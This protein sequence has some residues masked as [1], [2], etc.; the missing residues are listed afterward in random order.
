MPRRRSDRGLRRHTTGGSRGRCRLGRVRSTRPARRFAQPTAKGALS[1]RSRGR[2]DRQNR[3]ARLLQACDEP[4]AWHDCRAGNRAMQL[5]LEQCERRLERGRVAGNDPRHAASCLLVAASTLDAGSD[6]RPRNAGENSSWT[7]TDRAHSTAYVI[8]QRGGNFGCRGLDVRRRR[9]A[10][11]QGA[12]RRCLPRPRP[13]RRPSRPPIDMTPTPTAPRQAPP[14]GQGRS[15]GDRAP[16]R[17]LL[18][19]GAQDRRDRLLV[20]ER[21][22]PD[23]FLMVPV[24]GHAILPDQ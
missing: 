17:R 6:A 22:A 1:C 23:E 5:R 7:T 20:V 18:R 24:R 8:A 16:A 10:R 14:A 15:F 12:R 11:P 13:P 19:V 2:D 3:S 21:Q 4:L 9:W